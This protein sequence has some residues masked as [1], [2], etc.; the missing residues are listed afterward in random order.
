MNQQNT[1]IQMQ[2]AEALRYT[3]LKELKW[4]KIA[5]LVPIT[6]QSGRRGSRVYYRDGSYDDAAYIVSTLLRQLARYHFTSVE[7]ARALTK[8][9]PWVKKERMLN[10]LLG[11][12][13][14][15]VP[16]IARES[17]PDSSERLGYLVKQYLYSTEA[18]P[19]GTRI[20]FAADHAGIVIAQHEP[21]VRRQLMEAE[22]LEQH[23]K[24]LLAEQRRKLLE[25][26]AAEQNGQIG[27]Y[28]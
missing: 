10:M 14:T 1:P 25:Q 8:S 24:D 11:D 4:S 27:R 5:L 19:H 18:L 3:P 12:M 17:T 22:L 26:E 6:Q 13:C 21:T 7:H 20:K 2:L 28:K 9:C 16:V 23:Y 15:V